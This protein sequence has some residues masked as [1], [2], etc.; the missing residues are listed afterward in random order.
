MNK[1]SRKTLWRSVPV[2]LIVI[3]ILSI[4]TLARAPSAGAIPGSGGI[5]A[6]AG[7][8]PDAG[9]SA[10]KADRPAEHAQSS[11]AT[12]QYKIR[13]F[14]LSDIPSGGYAN[15]TYRY[16]LINDYTFPGGW[17]ERG[18]NN[19][20]NANFTGTP[21]YPAPRTSVSGRAI[22]M[23]VV[24]STCSAGNCMTQYLGTATGGVWKTV[25]GG[26]HWVRLFDH[27]LRVGIEA[28]TL[29][30]VNPNIIYAGTGEAGNSADSDHGIGIYRS[31]N[32]GQ[33]WTLLGHSDVTDGISDV[34]TNRTVSRILVDPRPSKGAGTTNA[35]LYVT[36]SSGTI[37]CNFTYDE[38]TGVPPTPLA[39][40]GFYLSTNGGQTW[41]KANPPG[42]R[43]RTFDLVMDPS[44][45]NVLYM[46]MGE[47]GIYRTTTDAQPI[48]AGGIGNWTRLPGQLPPF[49]FY[50]VQLDFARSTATSIPQI[51]YAAYDTGA[52]T[53]TGTPCDIR[54]P[55]CSLNG[56]EKI[57]KITIPTP[58]TPSGGATYTAVPNP[59]ACGN[60]NDGQCWYDMPIRVDPTNPNVIY[61]GGSANYDYLF[62]TGP[63]PCATFYPLPQQCRATLMKTTDGGQTWR[64]ISYDV[65]NVALHPD[66]HFIF[67][68]PADPS[69]VW[70]Q[71]DG[72]D[73]RAGGA[74]T[75]NGAGGAGTPSAWN[76]QNPGLGTLQFVGL[77]VGPGRIVV[78]GTQDNGTFLSRPGSTVGQHIALGDGG[79][80][81]ADPVIAGLYYSEQFGAQMF[82]H[83][84]PTCDF[85]PGLFPGGFPACGQTWIAPF[86]GD[87]FDL[88]G[89]SFY[90]PQ[91]TAFRNPDGS[92]ATN[93]IFHS[94]FRVWRSE[95][96]GGVDINN[97]GDA[98]N[99]PAERTANPSYWV[100]ISGD[101][102]CGPTDTSGTPS[103]G[104][105]VISTTVAPNDPNTVAVSTNYGQ[106]Y[107]TH[108]ALTPVTT[109]LGTDYCPPDTPDTTFNPPFVVY[110]ASCNYISGP[111]WTEID[112]TL[113]ALVPT[114]VAFAPHSTTHYY[115]TL[116]G[117][118]VN[119][120]CTAFNP[121]PCQHVWETTDDGA[122]FH[123]IN[124]T[125]PQFSLPDM[126]FNTI[127]VNQNNGHLYVAADIGVFVSINNGAQWERIDVGLPNVPVY[128][129]RLD[130]G[131]TQ[132]FAALHGRGIWQT[133]AQ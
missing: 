127:Q 24:P 98:T 114:E 31:L 130:P 14:P 46:A 17:L 58:A 71:N 101:L 92:A 9:G 21:L 32:G 11:Y 39:P 6:G 133:G 59:S 106:L 122:T 8:G 19:N 50:R 87:F 12:Q 43:F 54:T 7:R 28:L 67:I 30:P 91:T 68:D 103:C 113:P 73:F 2:T 63:T 18:P 97:D 64:D 74:N 38:C 78:G 34:F 52:N 62:A 86:F 110:Y 93:N 66:D 5:A 40:R 4:G 121:Q 33:T 27:N 131:S 55:S 1:I 44:N 41:R 100:P 125:G 48:A 22:S 102:S 51:L 76:D 120:G 84:N 115:V 60:A 37:G 112:G 117:F 80:G 104:G 65:N 108:N 116:S 70:T 132:L 69:T 36:T 29:D 109:N 94:T 95:D 72:G 25:D 16:N 42:A 45:P 89:G 75:P 79:Q 129:L 90:E 124:G 107:I 56:P 123:P 118:G 26:S 15:A 35:T 85:Q 83:V 61:A 13:A 88:G 3:A 111:T 20:P 99:D 128:Q 53:I 82:R 126:P 105:N 10:S 57:Y 77:G 119:A 96:Y 81:V 47:F 49:F 23:V